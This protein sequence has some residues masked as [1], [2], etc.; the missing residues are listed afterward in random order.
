MRNR[1]KWN[2]FVKIVSG[3][4]AAAV[5]VLAVLTLAGG[6]TTRYIPAIFGAGALFFLGFALIRP[7]R[8]EKKTTTRERVW[9][10]AAALVCL[11]AAAFTAVTVWNLI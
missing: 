3:L 9:F 1:N 2:I 5:L 6:L 10:A 11:A 7:A 8:G 4:G